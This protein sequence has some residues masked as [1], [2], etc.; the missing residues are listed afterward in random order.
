MTPAARAGNALGARLGLADAFVL[1]YAGNLGRAQELATL[2]EGADRLRG[3][4]RV[5]LLVVGDGAGRPWLE[6]EVR[7]RG[8]GNV[9]LLGP[10][11]R[12]EQQEFLAACDLGLVPLVAGM[13]G[14]SVPS[15]LYNFLAAGRPV[16]G[17]VEPGSEVDRVV[18]EHGAGWSVP[19]GD[20]EGFVAAVRA[21]AA[22]PVALAAMGRRARHAVDAHYDGASSIAG[23]DAIVRAAFA[24]APATA[25]VCE[26]T[27]P[28]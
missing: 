21:A 25:A 10:R 17:V 9:T 2:I 23:Y 27:G 8:L 15:R 1:L 14:V 7:A 19:P 3:D 20:V 12:A 28:V 22:D 4:P 24:E 26:G 11:P 5:H 13:W 6:Q 16:I 18:R